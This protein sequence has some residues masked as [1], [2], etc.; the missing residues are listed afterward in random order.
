MKGQILSRIQS[1]QSIRPKSITKQQE[2][3]ASLKQLKMPN[4]DAMA[5]FL[6][7]TKKSN[8]DSCRMNSLGPSSSNKK[9]RKGILLDPFR[10]SMNRSK[11]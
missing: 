8:K 11:I 2:E 7:L 10:K 9:N 4:P 6:N 1:Y 3:E 5:K